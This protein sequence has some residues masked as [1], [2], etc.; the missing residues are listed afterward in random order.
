MLD[1]LIRPHIDPFLNKAAEAIEPYNIPANLLT[2]AGFAIGLVGCFFIA[3]QAYIPGLILIL[4]NRVMDG[5]DGAVARKQGP[6]DFGAYIDIVSDMVFYAAFV[7]FFVMTQSTWHLAGLFLIFS[8][9]GT[10]AS[11]LAYAIIAEKRSLRTARNGKKSFFHMSGLAEGS[12]TILFMV[13]VCLA[14]GFFAP[15][16]FLFG[17]MCWITTI[18][19]CMD[20][21][22]TFSALEENYDQAESIR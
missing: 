13:I 1:S 18:G 22:R 12:E 17:L 20:A 4:I 3:V 6:S 5:L 16:A 15:L 14:P 21:W 8:Y 11:F 7:F 10:G 19:R 9:M 2:L